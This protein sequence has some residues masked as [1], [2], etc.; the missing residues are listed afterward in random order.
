MTHYL[1][2]IENFESIFEL[3]FISHQRSQQDGGKSF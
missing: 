3:K 1:G 2:E